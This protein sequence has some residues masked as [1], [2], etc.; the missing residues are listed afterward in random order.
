[1]WGTLGSLWFQECFIRAGLRCE[2]SLTPDRGEVL[3]GW[4]LSHHPAFCDNPAELSLPSGK[5]KTD[6]L[7]GGIG[8]DCLLEYEFQ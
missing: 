2:D 4:R 5:F 1:M 7:H 8:T 6:L 3:A